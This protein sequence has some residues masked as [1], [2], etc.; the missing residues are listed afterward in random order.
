MQRTGKENPLSEAVFNML[1]IDDKK[2]EIETMDEGNDL[3][4]FPYKFE[5]YNTPFILLLNA[6]ETNDTIN[7]T[8]TYTTSL[9]KKATIKKMADHYIDIIKQ[10]V[11]DN[12]IKLSGIKISH[13][14]LTVKPVISREDEIV[15]NF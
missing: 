3:N 9:F 7:I 2:D 4:I 5:K 1:T 10:A 13:D 6:V 12:S 11:E 14:L 15:F 8:L